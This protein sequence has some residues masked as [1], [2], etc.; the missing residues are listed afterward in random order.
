MGCDRGATKCVA[1]IAQAMTD[2]DPNT[3]LLSVGGCS[4]LPF[5]KLFHSSLQCIGG[6]TMQEALM[7]CGKGRVENRATP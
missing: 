7:R 2:L 6:Q 3:T 4:V 5:V 1:H